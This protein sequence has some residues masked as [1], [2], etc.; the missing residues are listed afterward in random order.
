MHSPHTPHPLFR[1]S[2]LAQHTFWCAVLLCSLVMR[3]G[4]SCSDEVMQPAPSSDAIHS[5]QLICGALNTLSGVS[6]TDARVA[7]EMNFERL[8]THFNPDFEG[9]VAIEFLKDID[10]AARL[11]RQQMVHVLVV[12]G[13]D[14]LLLSKIS[15]VTPLVVAAKKDSPLESY[16]LLTR[17][18][19]HLDDLLR[20]KQRRLVVHGDNSRDIGRLWLETALNDRGGAPMDHSFTDIQT[21]Q[22]PIRTILPVFFGQADACLVL[23][24]AFETMVELNPQIGVKL[25]VLMESPGFIKNLICIVDGVDPKMVSQIDEALRGLH[26][27]EVGRQLLVIFQL[28]RNFPFKPE[29]LVETERVFDRY[30]LMNAGIAVR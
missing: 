13:I 14:Y 26:T 9:G 12:S 27:T 3:P 5:M 7:I 6:P 25:H 16:V 10:A 18:G 24:S 29:Y 1:L 2:R 15:G 20:M 23:K 22:K 30:R 21:A 4:L 17:N 28:Q 8:T 19:I 11:I